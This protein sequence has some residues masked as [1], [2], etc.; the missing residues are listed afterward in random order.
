MGLL[1]KVKDM[2][3]EDEI[4]EV[5]EKEKPKKE[6]KKEESKGIFRRRRGEEGISTPQ[7]VTVKED[8]VEVEQVDEVTEDLP[9]KEEVKEVVPQQEEKEHFKDFDV[10]DFDVEATKKLQALD[11]ELVEVLDTKDMVPE[12]VHY[13]ETTVSQKPLYKGTGDPTKVSSYSNVEPHPI[14]QHVEVRKTFQPTPIISPIYGVLDKNYKKEEI[15]D[16]K[17][18]QRTLSY[19]STKI[20]LDQVREK[21]YGPTT[22][23]VIGVEEEEPKKE[24]DELV[25]KDLLYDMTEDNPPVV[26]K[27]TLADAEEYFNDLGLEYNVDYKDSKVE[28]A[29]GKHVKDDD[30]SVKDFDLDDTLEI[31]NDYNKDEEKEVVQEEEEQVEEPNVEVEE[32]KDLE[33]T[34]TDTKL[35][36]NLFDLIDAMYEDKE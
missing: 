30:N 32:E 20:S 21:A 36:D 5:E 3:F 13:S 35:E 15:V 24:D 2:L 7:K 34:K 19:E 28:E 1:D 9:V 17:D 12:E 6:P 25:N 26:N 31:E 23:E 22:E 11:E 16:R 14:Y 18:V 33:N 29:K 8:T 27:V 4:V 10:S